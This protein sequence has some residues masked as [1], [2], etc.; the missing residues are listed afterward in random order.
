[1]K[2]LRVGDPHITVRNLDEAERLIQ[3]ICKIADEGDIPRIEFLGDLM[4]THAVI[5]VEVQDF[6]RR[7]FLK[8]SENHEVFALVGNHDQPGSKE[9]EQQMNSINIFNSQ[10]CRVISNPSVIDGIAHIPYMSDHVAFLA[11]AQDL[12]NKGATKLL[13][14]HQNFT[15]SLYS[16]MIDPTLVPQE[17]I[18]TGHIHEQR[19]IGK[20]FQ[21]GTPKWDT[22]TDANEEKG[23]WIF[24]HNDDGSVKSK[25]FISTRDI[26]TPIVKHT[27]NEGNQDVVL[28]DRAKNYIELV[29]SSAWI[30]QMKKKYKGLASIKARPTDRKNINVDKDK[31][32][33]IVD[34]LDVIFKPINGVS[35]EEIRNYLKEVSNV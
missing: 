8:L 12:Y 29:G 33:S 17:A 25:E 4:H 5:R 14:A 23:I 10:Q 15:V 2:V 22:M 31:I 3:F 19:Q 11:A 27:L 20:V 1:L 18:I 30:T 9:K 28:D 21:V 6:W 34:F 32:F 35:K 7:A 16:D 13:I 24:I 26:V